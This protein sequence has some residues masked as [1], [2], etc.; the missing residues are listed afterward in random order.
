M[1]D[2]LIVDDDGEILHLLGRMLKRAMD[3]V[4][5]TTAPNGKAALE[6]VEFMNDVDYDFDLILSDWEM[7]KMDGL[8]LCHEIKHRGIASPF[9]LM[10]GANTD[11]IKAGGNNPDSIISKPCTPDILL[12]C[13]KKHLG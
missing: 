12:P 5:I 11:D 6:V 9:V 13:I 3:D 1:K 4:D 2:I 7:P 8:K 10:T